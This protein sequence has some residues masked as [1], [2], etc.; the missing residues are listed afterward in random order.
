[1]QSNRAILRRLAALM[2]VMFMM[3]AGSSALAASFKARINSDSAKVY[4]VPSASSNVF[5][6]NGKNT[7]VTVTAYAGN[8][9]RVS[10]RG[11]TGYIQIKDLNLVNRP[12]AYAA[13]NTTVYKT[14]S[15]S[16]RMGTLKAGKAVY[17]AGISGDYYRIQNASGSVTGYVRKGT[18]TTRSKLIAAYKNAMS[19][20]GNSGSSSSSGTTVSRPSSGSSSSGSSSSGSSSSG[21][22]TAVTSKIDKVLAKAVSLL[23]RPYAASD[24]PPSSFNCSSFV[25]YCFEEYGYDV[26]GTALKQS[27]DSSMKKVTSLS[28]VKRG[29]ILCFDTD[30]DNVC[31]HTAIAMKDDGD[32]FVEASQKAGTVRTKSMDSY[33]KGFFMWAMRP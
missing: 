14:A 25:K 30:G 4:K 8:W 27:T 5:V 9:A 16:S 20:A 13:K 15:Y 29:D 10:Y 26:E 6:K 33:Y 1:M 28:S 12:K 2:A 7:V 23:G 17:V 22:G 31:D 19:A 18:L 21:T 11:N 3:A 32:T 24:N